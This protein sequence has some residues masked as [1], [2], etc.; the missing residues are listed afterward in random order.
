MFKFF[1]VSDNE[2]SPDIDLEIVDT[3]E[4]VLDEEVGQIALDVLEAEDEIYII[5][6]IAGVEQEKIDIS[7]NK[8]ILTLKGNREKPEEYHIDGI[9]S[10]NSEVFFGKFVRNIIL[11][12]NL[13]LNKI[14]AYM[15]NNLL[16]ISIPKMKFDSK[17]VKI[18]K[19]EG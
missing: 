8:T 17:V 6:P 18:N 14:R 12:E 4:E 3:K 9:I 2:K 13:A 11:P 10:K 15:E 19:I 16:I 5:A 1:G 7:I